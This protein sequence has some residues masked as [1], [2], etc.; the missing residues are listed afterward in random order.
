MSDIVKYS[1]LLRA[2]RYVFITIDKLVL[3]L[4]PVN[5]NALRLIVQII[6]REYITR[7]LIVNRLLPSVLCPMIQQSSDTKWK[8]KVIKTGK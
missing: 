3:Y 2:F 4:T 6:A 1:N 8:I 7:D 5:P